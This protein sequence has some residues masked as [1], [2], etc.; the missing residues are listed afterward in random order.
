MAFKRRWKKN[1]AALL[2]SPLL[3][4]LSFIG[5]QS[6]RQEIKPPPQR[7]GAQSLRATEGRGITNRR[8]R[9]SSPRILSGNG[10]AI[11]QTVFSPD[12]RSLASVGWSRARNAV[13]VALWDVAGGAPRSVL[14]R[15]IKVTALAA[16][17]SGGFAFS[18]FN[19]ALWDGGSAPRRTMPLG[20]WALA[21]ALAFSPSGH[22]LAAGFADGH[23]RLWDA[24]R[25]KPRLTFRVSGKLK[26][27]AFSRDG[28]VLATAG[29]A[30]PELDA[31]RFFDAA[32]GAL[33][34]SLPRVPGEKFLAGA[35]FSPDLSKVATMAWMR[36]VQTYDNLVPMLHV[37]DARTGGVLWAHP[38]DIGYLGG[39]V[40][41]PNSEFVA[42]W[43]RESVQLH[44][45][46]TGNLLR[47]LGLP[48]REVAHVAF[49][50]NGRTLS[51]AHHDRLGEQIG[52]EA[53]LW[54]ISGLAATPASDPATAW[55]PRAAQ[56]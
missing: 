39:A 29:A 7:T 9:T 46:R 47:T 24:S 18:D 19:I 56:R 55:I 12:G 10:I 38:L 50:S 33:K 16:S 20:G 11:S 26:A 41:S 40:F 43:R 1:E 6:V 42:I 4:L 23:I 52:S 37:R 53:D 31:I 8:V 45:A 21:S 36:G 49:S 30:R 28:T 3:V 2:A 27:L 17:P 5:A 15:K 51:C 48:Y 32:T 22:L 44:D 13:E 14:R 25:G 54:D 34:R 35:A